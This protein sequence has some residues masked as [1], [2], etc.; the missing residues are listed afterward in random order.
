MHG[1]EHT[2]VFLMKNGKL[3]RYINWTKRFSVLNNL[4]I[5][6]AKLTRGNP[7]HDI[8][9]IKTMNIRDEIN[10]VD[11]AIIL[12]QNENTNRTLWEVGYML[13]NMFLQAKSLNISYASKIFN[14]NE[15]KKIENEGI[16][17]A[18][19]ALLL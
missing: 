8:H 10:G 18:V 4:F 6:Y 1:Q 15:I 13:E 3:F 5:N 14:Y 7:S 17:G 12:S 2:K 19:A 16:R 9:F 11:T